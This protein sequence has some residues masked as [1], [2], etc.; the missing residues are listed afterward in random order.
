MSE[1]ELQMRRVLLAVQRAA[2]AP[3][4]EWLGAVPP[5]QPDVNAALQQALQDQQ[6]AA[7]IGAWG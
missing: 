3:P 6:D 5:E 4:E 7:F 1:A 2:A